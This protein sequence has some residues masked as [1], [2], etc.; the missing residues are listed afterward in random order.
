MQSPARCDPHLGT[1]GQRKV[2]CGRGMR[3]H[4]L[5]NRAL[6]PTGHGKLVS[7]AHVNIQPFVGTDLV[8]PSAGTVGVR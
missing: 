8:V 4:T 2:T 1:V 3:T 5:L 6:K 7:E